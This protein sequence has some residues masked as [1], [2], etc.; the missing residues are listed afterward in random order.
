MRLELRRGI[1]ILA[2]LTALGKEQ[3]GY[4]PRKASAAFTTEESNNVDADY[5]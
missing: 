2:V 3:Y 5:Q 1:L 4:S